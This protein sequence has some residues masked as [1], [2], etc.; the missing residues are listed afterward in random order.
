MSK[1]TYN[2]NIFPLLDPVSWPVSH[3]KQQGTSIVELTLQYLCS[4]SNRFI[5]DIQRRIFGS[6]LYH[7]QGHSRKKHKHPLSRKT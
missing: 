3:A 1:D 6:C 7:R 4:Y 2:C 5:E